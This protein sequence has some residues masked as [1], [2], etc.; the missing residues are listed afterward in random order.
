MKY[1]ITSK[2]YYSEI[3]IYT[4]SMSN[5]SDVEARLLWFSVCWYS[6]CPGRQSPESWEQL[7]LHCIVRLLASLFYAH[8]M[9]IHVSTCVPG[10]SCTYSVIWKW[11]RDDCGERRCEKMHMLNLSVVT[12]K[13]S[14]RIFF[15]DI[16]NPPS[17]SLSLPQ[18]LARANT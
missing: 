16:L 18:T 8:L 7:C 5:T 14:K 6:W 10:F 11:H 12:N 17:L 2:V 9:W 13:N 15:Y 3:L 4:R 1:I